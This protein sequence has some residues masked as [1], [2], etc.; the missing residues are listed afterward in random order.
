MKKLIILVGLVFVS[1][2]YGGEYKEARKDLEK[3]NLIMEKTKRTMEETRQDVE[4]I[5]KTEFEIGVLIGVLAFQEELESGEGGTTMFLGKRASFT[6]RVM[7]R[8]Y[9][10]RK[11]RAEERDN[12]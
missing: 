9:A 4:K 1:G 7:A 3:I 8:A 6:E 11:E 5:R 12:P 2:C 10:I